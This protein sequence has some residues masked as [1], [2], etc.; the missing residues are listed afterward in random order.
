MP[1][2]GDSIRFVGLFDDALKQ[3]SEEKQ[4][5]DRDEAAKKDARLA[6]AS[7]A[8]A[9][10]DQ[11]LKECAAYLNKTVGPERF[12]FSGRNIWP[13]K[14]PPGY[15][16]ESHSSGDSYRYGAVLS[17]D[18]QI[19]RYGAG[20]EGYVPI[21]AE[22]LSEGIDL[23]R[24]SGHNRIVVSADGTPT[25]SWSAGYDDGTHLKPLHQWL[26]E[27]ALGLVNDR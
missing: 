20:S 11:M 2:E 12:G 5:R 10:V 27:F 3:Q 23:G 14:S 13:K 1:V 8:A 6:R 21:T 7:A 16:L 15:L 25:F 19:W 22:N 4:R 17:A 9:A 18:G 24:F 26:A